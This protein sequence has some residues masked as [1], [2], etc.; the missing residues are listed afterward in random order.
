VI[1]A[2]YVVTCC[3]ALEPSDHRNGA[4]LYLGL[5]DLQGTAQQFERCSASMSSMPDCVP[6]TLPLADAPQGLLLLISSG[7]IGDGCPKL[8]GSVAGNTRNCPVIH[9]GAL[10]LAISASPGPA[11]CIT[12]DASY[13]TLV[14]HDDPAAPV[15]R[16]RG[17]WFK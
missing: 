4:G 5:I 1:Y 15:R 12:P 9:E 14:Y 6:D 17:S 11:S 10:P 13:I 16:Q 7:T 8:R 2:L 3:E